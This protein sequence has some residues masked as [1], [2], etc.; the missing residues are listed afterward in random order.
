[1]AAKTLGNRINTKS[2][3]HTSGSV[4][5]NRNMEESKESFFPRKWECSYTCN[6]RFQKGGSFP[7]QVGVFHGVL[8]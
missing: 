7:T 8:V 3:S 5:L 1:M 6:R 2:F 4:P